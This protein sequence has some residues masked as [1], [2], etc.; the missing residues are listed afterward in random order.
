MVL[1]FFLPNLTELQDNN[2]QTVQPPVIYETTKEVQTTK[3][4]PQVVKSQCTFK[5]DGSCTCRCRLHRDSRAYCQQ[6]MAQ[7]ENTNRTKHSKF[8]RML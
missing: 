7:D 8:I 3:W 1:I 6:L 2:K 5:N 4:T